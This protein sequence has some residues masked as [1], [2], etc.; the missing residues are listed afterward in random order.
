[1]HYDSPFLLE[2]SFTN[3]FYPFAS[4]SPPAAKPS[5]SPT[6]LN[7]FFCHDYLCEVFQQIPDISYRGLVSLLPP[8]ISLR[9]TDLNILLCLPE[10]RLFRIAISLSAPPRFA[11]SVFWSNFQAP[12]DFFSP[13]FSQTPVH[14]TTTGWSLLPYLCTDRTLF[15]P[16]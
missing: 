8:G 13:F 12:L 2:G 14:S 7:Q 10:R 4:P 9:T 16:L 1:M 3:E 6:P 15:P 5:L 11:F